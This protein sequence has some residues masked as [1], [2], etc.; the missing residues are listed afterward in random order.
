MFPD[1][2]MFS[3][4]ITEMA[5][6]LVTKKE[7]SEVDPWEDKAETPMQPWE[8]NLHARDR[9]FLTVTLKAG[10]GYDAPWLVFHANSVDEA[11]ESLQH[12]KLDELMDLTARKG[13]EL[14]KAFGGS[15]SF[16]KPAA[17]SSGGWNKSAAP[18]ASSERP[19]DTCPDH[20]C[21]LVFADKFT[22]PKTQKVISA[23]MGCPVPNCRRKTY[24]L[25]DDGTWTLKEQ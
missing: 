3:T 21:P 14:A 5:N 23:K 24:W 11:L 4:P 12:D 17:A 22:N 8:L 7:T 25:N 20:N 16:S 18:A 10:T 13:K 19:S 6:E 1:G 2:M 15:Q 9:D